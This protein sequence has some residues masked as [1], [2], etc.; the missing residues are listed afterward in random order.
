MTVQQVID[1]Q[2]QQRKNQQKKR[3]QDW[4]RNN[5]DKVRIYKEKW[6]EKHPNYYNN[7]FKTKKGKQ[8]H[9]KAMKKYNEKKKQERK[10]SKQS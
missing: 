10:E 8:V 4:R 9:N 6:L 2:E 5:P 1:I 7:Y 3:M